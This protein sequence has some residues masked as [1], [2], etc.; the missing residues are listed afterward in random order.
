MHRW[1]IP[2]M[3][4]LALLLALGTS[5]A[6]AQEPDLCPGEGCEGWTDDH[7]HFSVEYGTEKGGE[8]VV[9]GCERVMWVPVLVAV[10]AGVCYRIAYYVDCGGVVISAKEAAIQQVPCGV[11]GAWRRICD[12]TS[13]FQLGGGVCEWSDYYGQRVRLSVA[14]PPHVLRITPY[15]V[16]MVARE[17]LEGDFHPT[18]RVT[19]EPP[20]IADADSG[21]RLWSWGAS[22]G[23]GQAPFPCAM[24]EGELMA[25][26][27]PAGTTC[28]RLQLWAA[29]G[30][31][32]GSLR[33]LGLPGVLQF[34][35]ARVNVALAP[36]QTVEISFP[37][38]SHPATK[39]TQP[40]R[41]GGV[42]WPAF[43][44]YFQ[45][46][47]AVRLRVEE[48][49]V[50]DRMGEQ[51]R[52]TPVE[53]GETG[54]CWAVVG[55]ML[56]WGKRRVEPVVVG[57]EWETAESD[58]ILALRAL[59]RPYDG[60]HADQLIIL[61]PDRPWRSRVVMRQGTP[62]LWCPLAVR[63]GQGAVCADP[64]CGGYTP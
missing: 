18:A 16:G 21:W 24:G 58:G 30:F 2:V 6:Q 32:A 61:G 7:S 62:W 51:E 36:G 34:P 41:F 40:V 46:W 42:E 12:P 64:T 37:Y 57:K 63:E 49:R 35:A 54:D 50:R 23:P 44:G 3:A 48:K 19:W 56:R 17:G 11:V 39:Q 15:P 60:L 55:G 59:G 13:G 14:V 53:K 45:R 26:G 27:V 9:R 1:W 28:L 47:W 29:P 52:C 5:I 4:T 22:R 33:P 25:H 38:A 20:A 43:P 31:A 10:D 8:G